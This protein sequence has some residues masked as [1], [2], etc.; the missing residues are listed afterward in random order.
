MQ[1]NSKLYP[2]TMLRICSGLSDKV[3]YP[4]YNYVFLLQFYPQSILLPSPWRGVGGEA[5]PHIP[6]SPTLNHWHYHLFLGLI[7]IGKHQKSI[8]GVVQGINSGTADCDFFDALMFFVLLC[9]K[10]LCIVNQL[11]T[12]GRGDAVRA[13]RAIDKGRIIIMKQ[14]IIIDFGRLSNNLCGI[15]FLLLTTEKQA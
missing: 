12:I 9:N 11:F 10:H 1:I 4:T 2:F 7:S 15:F 6:H 3:N 5:S 13:K 8:A 14:I